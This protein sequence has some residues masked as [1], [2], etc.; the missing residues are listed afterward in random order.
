MKYFVVSHTVSPRHHEVFWN[1]EILDHAGRPSSQ[2]QVL[3]LNLSVNLTR[4]GDAHIAAYTLFLGMSLRAFLEE[5]SIWTSGLSKAESLPQSGAASF[6]SWKAWIEHG[7]VEGNR[8][9]LLSSWL[10]ELRHHLLPLALLALGSSGLDWNLHPLGSLALS[11]SFELHHRSFW[12]P[13]CR[14]R[15][16]GRLSF[17]DR[18]SQCIIIILFIHIWTHTIS[19]WFC[20]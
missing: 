3:R 8:L 7:R 16:A 20:F 5:M 13:A 11:L 6:N 19:Y 12:S 4:P 10:T 18:M 14:W 15:T 1:E 17:H 9:R 2:W